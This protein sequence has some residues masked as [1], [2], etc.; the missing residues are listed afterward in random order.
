MFRAFLD[1]QIRRVDPLQ[2][3]A[4]LLL[5]LEAANELAQ[6]GFP[7]AVPACDGS[8]LPFVQR[9]G[10]ILERLESVGIA[11]RKILHFQKRF[12]RLRLFRLRGGL[13]PGAHLF[14]IRVAQDERLDVSRT[15]G[16][17]DRHPGVLERRNIQRL[18]DAGLLQQTAAEKFPGR[19]IRQDAAFVHQD[20]PVHMAVQH[21]LQAVLDDDDRLV[22]LLRD[23][24][25]Q[26]D[27]S[28]SRRGIQIRQR[29]VEQQHVH[30]VHENAGERYALFLAAG[31]LVRRMGKMPLHIHEPCGRIHPPLHLVHRH[32]VIFEGEGDVFRDGE[33]DKL[34]VGVLQHRADHLGT[35][36]DVAV[37][38]FF[39]ADRKAAGIFSVIRKRRQSVETRDERRF[40]AA[41][42]PCDEDLLAGIDVQVDVVQRRFFLNR[43]LKPEVFKRDDG[44]Q[45]YFFSRLSFLGFVAEY[46]THRIV[47]TMAVVTI[48]ARAATNPCRNTLFQGSAYITM[49]R[50]GATTTHASTCAT[51]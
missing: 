4:A 16:G 27:G 24:V 28:L 26:F 7:S 46:A 6:R 45:G 2:E 12:C 32:L 42:R 31:Q 5:A 19:R 1:A 39:A 9:K 22:L 48:L 43:V 8:H 47:P 18:P 11:E 33:P 51:I 50:I 17:V 30:V 38:G 40:A 21:V 41:G 13:E 10:D 25:D 15:H 49:S 20:D 36:K 23:A 3:D 37:A 14:L 29:L 34:G 35:G 44:F